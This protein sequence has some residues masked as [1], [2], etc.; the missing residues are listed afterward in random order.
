VLQQQ[1]QRAWS[2]DL[3]ELLLPALMLLIVYW[4]F[5]D[6]AGCGVKQIALS[7]GAA[8]SHTSLLND[9]Y[10]RLSELDVLQGAPARRRQHK[11]FY[12]SYNCAPTVAAC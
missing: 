5:T 1:V 12:K 9:I 7:L 4:Q 6:L 10:K 3:L 11:A 2:V 8:F